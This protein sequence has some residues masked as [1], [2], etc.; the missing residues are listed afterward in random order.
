V[1]ANDARA[2]IATIT[3]RIDKRLAAI[4]E[5]EAAIRAELNRLNSMEPDHPSDS[6]LSI[7]EACARLHVSRA[8]M[9]RLMSEDRDLR[10]LK[11]GK[12]TLFR[13]EDITAYVAAK[14]APVRQAS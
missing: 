5:H 1:R 12:R 7:D 13:P 3:D 11:I 4:A 10:W 6:L 14:M 9:F 2:Q 8:T